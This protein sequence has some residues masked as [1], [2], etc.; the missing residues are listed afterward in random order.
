MKSIRANLLVQLLVAMALSVA[1]GGAGSYSIVRSGMMGVVDEQLSLAAT[2]AR[3][4]LSAERRSVRPAK[5]GRAVRRWMQ[6]EQE[7]N[8]LYF[9]AWNRDMQRVAHSSALGAA[10]LPKPAAKQVADKLETLELSDGRRLRALTFAVDPAGKRVSVRDTQ[11]RWVVIARDL[12]DTDRTLSLL[13]GS[14]AGC[15]VAVAVLGSVLVGRGLRNGL[16]PLQQLAERASAIEVDSLATRF[17][18]AGL[19]AELVP[20]ARR[21]NDLMG[22]LECG[23]ERER[24][25]SADLAHEMRTPLAELRAMAELAMQW[26]DQAT[27]ETFSGVLD[28]TARMQSMVETLLALARWESRADAAACEP[29]RPAE[30][31]RAGFSSLEKQAGARGLSW[32]FSVPDSLVW[33]S[34]P[35]VLRHI[36]DNL[37]ANAVEYADAPGCIRL[38]AD[39]T[40]LRLSNPA[41]HLVPEDLP[42]LFDRCWRRD[43][44]RSGSAHFGLGLPLARACA[45]ALGMSLTAELHPGVLT[46]D[47]RFTQ[48]ES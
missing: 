47:L 33:Q 12:E 32:D 24:R 38:H 5:Q 29:V 28:V 18:E 22:R 1:L 3:E 17:D 10:A 11:P 41:S 14:L 27:P 16:V 21:L 34:D 2:G 39:A 36:L 30:L 25:F 6:F 23:F 37:L 9:E 35:A 45:G 13:L 7:E 15:G 46:L 42:R 20:I 4:I 48:P 43:P 44:A 40:G 19:P 26:P 8:G 31:V